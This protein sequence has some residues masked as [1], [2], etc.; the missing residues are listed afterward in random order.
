MSQVLD[1]D[2][3]RKHIQVKF[4][5]SNALSIT[6]LIS[7]LAHSATKALP[8]SLRFYLMRCITPAYI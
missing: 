8:A 2:L 1:Y 7:V 6:G 3:V 5:N 4:N